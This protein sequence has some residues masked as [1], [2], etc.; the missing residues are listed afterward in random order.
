[1]ASLLTISPAT[2][3]QIDLE[4]DTIELAGFEASQQYRRGPDPADMY[5]PAALLD[6]YTATLLPFAKTLQMDANHARRL[7]AV[8]NSKPSTS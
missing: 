4:R 1:M 5:E 3:S 7:R 8:W 6:N 2:G